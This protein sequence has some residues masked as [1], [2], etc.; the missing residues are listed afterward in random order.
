[1]AQGIKAHPTSPTSGTAYSRAG[2]GSKD[3]RYHRKL[4]YASAAGSKFNQLSAAWLVS[5]LHWVA[6]EKIKL[7]CHNGCVCIRINFLTATQFKE[8]LDYVR[9]EL[10]FAV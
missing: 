1:M 8:D 6:V 9:Q 2:C 7:G 5:L 4:G 10:L 3:W